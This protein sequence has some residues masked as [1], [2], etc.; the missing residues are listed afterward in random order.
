MPGFPRLFTRFRRWQNA[1][2]VD[3]DRKIQA[4]AQRVMVK[5][6]HKL[7]GIAALAEHLGVSE[8]A[9]GDFVTGKVVPSA[10]QVLKAV[11]TL[12]EAGPV[13]HWDDDFSDGDTP[14]SR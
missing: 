3:A 7:G 8:A 14:Q 10:D 13:P 9:V 6:A 4:L 5:S 2:A 1:V 11:A 12:M